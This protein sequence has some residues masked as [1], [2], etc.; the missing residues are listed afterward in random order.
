LS[1]RRPKQPKPSPTT[2]VL[3]RNSAADWIAA[4]SMLVF[5]GL[6]AVASLRIIATYTVFNHATYTVFNHT[7][8]EPAHV[9]CGMEWL[10]KGVYHYETQHPP[11]A[12]VAA[13][14]Y[15]AGRRLTEAA[16]SPEDGAMVT[17]TMYEQGPII[18]YW[19]NHY[20]RNLA[21]ARLGILPFFWVACLVV[22]F[23]ARKYFGGLVA[24]VAVFLFTF[25]PPTLAHGGLATTDTPLAAWTGASFFVALLWIEHPDSK[26]SLLFGA[27]TGLAV[28][29]KFSSLLFLPAAFIAALAWYIAASRPNVSTLAEAARLRALPFLLAVITGAVVIWA[30]YRFSFGKA[31][32]ANVSL[33]APELYAGIREVFSHNK[34]GHP[35]YL[36]GM[37]SNF[38]W[39]YYYPVVLAVK[40]PLPFLALL[41]A[42]VGVSLKRSNRANARLWMPL[43]FSLGILFAS[44][45]SNINIGVRHVLPV[46][47]GFSIPAALGVEWLLEGMRRASWAKW[48]FSIL[49]IWHGATSALSHPDYIPYTNVLAGAEPEKILVDSDLDWGQDMK[50]LGRHL[51]ELGARQVAFSPLIQGY[52]ERAHGFPP[53]QP[54]DPETPAAGWNAA[55]VTKML[56]GRFGLGSEHPEIKFWT[57]SI[58]PT[59][60]L[61]KTTYLWYF[62]PAQRRSDL[63]QNK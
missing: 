15:L 41:F 54:M 27:C 61:G 2:A 53:I 59:E 10:Q 13:A 38:G 16:L 50:R 58:R 63:S 60:K 40:T 35:A 42:G 36:L 22:Y 29:S 17:P 30:G 45:F 14:P 18:L 47:L 9:A 33:P 23:W 21:L 52:L 55:S 19:D 39:W 43:A 37:H 28:L 8:D 5:L 62:P 6:I 44:L 31:S 11:L 51:R 1:K 34:E 3:N 48:A 7:I 25:L 12:R 56:A 57:D 26:R 24:S 49:L 46:Y 32:F 4:H 20:D